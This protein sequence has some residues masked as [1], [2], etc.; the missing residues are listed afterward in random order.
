MSPSEPSR[1]GGDRVSKTPFTR[2][3]A[4]LRPRFFRAPERLVGGCV[5]AMLETI[6]SVRGQERPVQLGSRN[7]RDV[8]VQGLG[9]VFGTFIPQTLIF[10]LH[11][12]DPA[13]ALV[14]CHPPTVSQRT[15]RE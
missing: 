11:L 6:N 14:L 4:G 3:E 8:Y 10:R 5:V 7:S 12:F 13:R 15:K 9:T 1:I 2:P